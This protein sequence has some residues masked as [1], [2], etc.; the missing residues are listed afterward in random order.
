MEDLR[1][2]KVY[3]FLRSMRFGMILL[4]LV[5]LCSLAGS[6]IPQGG[7]AMDYVQTY[8]SGKASF[9]MRIGLTDVFHTWYFYLLEGLVCLNLLLCSIVRFPGTRKAFSRLVR[10]AAAAAPDQPLQPEEAVRLEKWLTQRRFHREETAQ[11]TVY[12]RNHIGCYG[13]FLTHLAIL[14]VLIFGGLALMTPR[15]MDRTV[16]P[17]DTLTLED[18]TRIRCLD[19]HI[20]N[21]EGRLD[22]TSRLRVADA[23]G[24]IG[25]EQEIR[26]NEPMR[27]GEYKIYQQTY[28]TAGQVR[29]RNRANGAEETLYLTEACFLSVDSENGIWFNALYPGFVVDEDGNY[30]L[31]THTSGRYEDPVYSVQ[32]IAEGMSASVLAFPGET[33]S[34]GDIDFTFLEPVEYPGLRIKQVSSWVYSGLYCGFGLMVTGL[35]LCFFSVPSAVKVTCEGYAVRSPKKQG[36]LIELAALLAQQKEDG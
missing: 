17:G 30:T 4:L 21:E 13:S 27:F 34:I 29:I 32:S 11:G 8:G 18:G 35:F 5:M 6:L 14:L 1:L 26:V 19:F 12:S 16:M 2:K 25:K 3:G 23:D 33:M 9:L 20:L 24:S 36:L 15:V 28:G 10:E 7:K 22:Y 31:I